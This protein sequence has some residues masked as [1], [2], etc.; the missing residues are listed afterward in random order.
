MPSDPYKAEVAPLTIS[1]CCTNPQVEV[2][3]AEG[4]GAK[5]ITAR[6][7][8]AIHQHQ[9]AIALQAT[10]IEARIAVATCARPAAVNRA[11]AR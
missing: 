6:L 8:N 4:I 11:G 10:D 2:V 7:A 1:T 9:H 5:D 3:A